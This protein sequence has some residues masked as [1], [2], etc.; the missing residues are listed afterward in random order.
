MFHSDTHQKGLSGSSPNHHE[1]PVRPCV[2]SS[3]LNT[4]RKPAQNSAPSLLP[5]ILFQSVSFGALRCNFGC[6]LFYFLYLRQKPH[7][8]LSTS[9]YLIVYVPPW[10]EV[11][12]FISLR[13]TDLAGF[14]IEGRAVVHIGIRDSIVHVESR[15]TALTA[16]VSVAT[17]KTKARTRNSSKECH[18]AFESMLQN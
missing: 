18:P 16:I 4:S 3:G 8:G 7:F 11:H 17:T 2:S 5:R 1:T 6:L 12:S 9:T 10:G 13:Q 15:K 14:K